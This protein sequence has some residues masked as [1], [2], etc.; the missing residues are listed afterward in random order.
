MVEDDADDSK[1]GVYP[2]LNQAVVFAF[3]MIVPRVT[4]LTSLNVS[5]LV[6]PQILRLCIGLYHPATRLDAARLTKLPRTTVTVCNVSC[7]S[8]PAFPSAA[9]SGRFCYPAIALH[10]T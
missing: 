6:I 10:G 5:S 7:I 4:S 9:H 2:S 8:F 1:N 3:I